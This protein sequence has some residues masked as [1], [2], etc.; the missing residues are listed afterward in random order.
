MYVKNYF[1]FS[2]VYKNKAKC[3]MRRGNFR[4]FVKKSFHILVVSS[5]VWVLEACFAGVNNLFCS[6]REN[7]K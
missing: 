1:T 6:K 2:L 7:V 4:P 3:E 5:F